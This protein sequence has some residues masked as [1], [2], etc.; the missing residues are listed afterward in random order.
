ML[1]PL[2][3]RLLFFDQSL[4]TIYEQMKAVRTIKMS[5]CINVAS[6]RTAI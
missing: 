5:T 1:P 2:M 4:E 6:Y 3:I